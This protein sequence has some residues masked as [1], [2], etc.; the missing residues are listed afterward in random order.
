MIEKIC[1]NAGSDDVT[2][3]VVKCMNNYKD[4]YKCC[5]DTQT[6]SKMDTYFFLPATR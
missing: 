1:R 2:G 5:P 4:L 6:Y 3:S